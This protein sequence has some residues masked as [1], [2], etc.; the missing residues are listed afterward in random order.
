M[1][2]QF[3]LLDRIHSVASPVT[4]PA[5]REMTHAQ[6]RM[7][8]IEDALAPTTDRTSNAGAPKSCANTAP[9]VYSLRSTPTSTT[10]QYAY[11]S[12]RLC[13]SR[14]VT[15]SSPRDTTTASHH[16]DL[17]TGR[18]APSKAIRPLQAD[19]VA[20]RDGRDLALSVALRK[21]AEELHHV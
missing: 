17:S 9:G 4:R 8:E 1:L 14:V 10:L 16:H 3:H 19:G 11:A 2:N 12:V 13:V 21:V 5:R 18:A 7:M 6:T 20:R 15:I